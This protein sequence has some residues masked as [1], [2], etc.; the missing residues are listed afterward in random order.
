[1]KN[2]KLVKLVLVI[3]ICAMILLCTAGATLAAN[4]T[5]FTEL[6]ATDLTTTE[7][8]TDNNTVNS[9]V[10]NTVNNT[11]V[12]TTNNV[13]TYNNTTLP[14]TGIADSMPIVVLA[15]AFGISAIYAYKK[16]Q[17]YKSL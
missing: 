5:T 14:D 4:N 6:N 8:S 1:M 2:G 17:D 9:T 15:V 10:N 12:L 3:G 16:I 11:A 13:T 7:N